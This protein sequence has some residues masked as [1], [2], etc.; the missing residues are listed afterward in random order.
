MGAV[1]RGVKLDAVWIVGRVGGKSWA[2][3]GG[4]FEVAEQVELFRIC[5]VIGLFSQ[6]E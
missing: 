5:A 1:R 6:G 4:S 2:E 3:E